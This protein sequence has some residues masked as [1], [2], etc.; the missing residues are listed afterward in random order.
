MGHPSHDETD[1]GDALEITDLD[2]IGADSSSL[3][4]TSH[5]LEKCSLCNEKA[6]HQEV[7]KSLLAR[8]EKDNS[9]SLIGIVGTGITRTFRNLFLLR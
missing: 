6:Y 8:N 4:A 3:L 9:Y 7:W 5:R 2:A 1:S